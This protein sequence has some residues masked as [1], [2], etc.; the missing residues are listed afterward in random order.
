MKHIVIFTAIFGTHPTESNL[1]KTQWTVPEI[2]DVPEGWN[3]SYFLITD[4]NTSKMNSNIRNI[5]K[6]WNIINVNY[7][8]ENPRLEARK[9]KIYKYEY[10]LPDHDISIWI[11]SNVSLTKSCFSEMEKLPFESEI[12]TLRH[13]VRN[14]TYD[15]IEYCFRNGMHNNPESFIIQKKIYEKLGFPADMGLAETRI[16]SRKK[17]NNVLLF[18]KVWWEL[19]TSVKNY[20]LRDQCSFIPALWTCELESNIAYIEQTCDKFTHVFRLN[21]RKKFRQEYRHVAISK[22]KRKGNKVPLM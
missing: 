9:Y 10:V 3:I 18:N 5:D 19:F 4:K 8:V 11:D 22:I 16:I 12:W 13:P 6:K 17:T 1:L 20:H 7:T 14:C 21:K 2:Q 15:E